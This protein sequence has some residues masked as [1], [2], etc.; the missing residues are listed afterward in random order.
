MRTTSVMPLSSQDLCRTALYFNR[1]TP[2]LVIYENRDE[3]SAAKSSAKNQSDRSHF[4]PNELQNGKTAPRLNWL[5]ASGHTA[6]PP[7]AISVTM[8]VTAAVGCGLTT[9]KLSS[10]ARCLLSNGDCV[11]ADRTTWLKLVCCLFV[12]P[13]CDG[14]QRH[15]SSTISPVAIIDASKASYAM[16]PTLDRLRELPDHCHSR[17]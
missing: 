6:K 16:M 4:C 14:L 17:S 1:L 11:V 13:S 7:I 9:T 2:R 10:I 8:L 5:M 3:T 12:S 15:S